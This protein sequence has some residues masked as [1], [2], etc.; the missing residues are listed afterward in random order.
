MGRPSPYRFSFCRLE[1]SFAVVFWSFSCSR[2]GDNYCAC[3]CVCITVVQFW[4]TSD[5]YGVTCVSLYIGINHCIILLL[6]LTTWRWCVC[7]V[8]DWFYSLVWRRIEYLKLPDLCLYLIHLA[9]TVSQ[10]KTLAF[11]RN[12]DRCKPISETF[13]DRFSRRTSPRI[14]VATVPCKQ[15]LNYSARGGGYLWA[16]G[17][18]GRSWSPK[19]R[20][21]R[22]GSRPPTWGFRA[23]VALWLLWHLNSVWR[24]QHL[25]T[26]SMD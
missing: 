26:P 16:R 23:F 21:Q 10:K 6:V 14:T 12:R 11:S 18:K 25:S 17:L 15:W 4:L 24:L 1:A 22:W 13:T 20:E 19:G 5:V 7:A 9:Y 3:V 2:V 8:C